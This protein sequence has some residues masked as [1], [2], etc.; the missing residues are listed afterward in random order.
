MT[1]SRGVFQ[2]DLGRGERIAKHVLAELFAFGPV[3]RWHRAARV[4]VE[5]GVLPRAH[6]LDEFEAQ[7]FG[8][9]VGPE[10]FFQNAVGDF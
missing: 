7:Q 4:H 10:E 9:D 1:V 2:S 8:E 6:A 3:L 5:A